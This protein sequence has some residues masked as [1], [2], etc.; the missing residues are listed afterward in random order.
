MPYVR[1]VGVDKWAPFAGGTAPGDAEIAA[2]AEDL[3]RDGA[4]SVYDCA[5]TADREVVAVA[6]SAEGTYKKHFNYIC[7]TDADLAAAGARAEK[8]VG[9]TP[10]PVANA[11]HYE[12][13]L[14]PSGAEGLV[15]VLVQRRITTEKILR[16]RLMVVAKELHAA[17]QLNDLDNRHWL[18][19]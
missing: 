14:G 12:V 2:A 5:S 4:P 9:E 10:C 3:E 7:I 1:R 19:Q 17:G 11:L 18:L 13:Q 6:V 16:E 15:R 8:I